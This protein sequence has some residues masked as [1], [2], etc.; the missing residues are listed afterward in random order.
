MESNFLTFLVDEVFVVAFDAQLA[1]GIFDFGTQSEDL[2]VIF[3]HSLP[4]H[5]SCS[6]EEEEIASI[7]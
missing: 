1:L 4:S 2:D 7:F 5:L 3:Q 6:N